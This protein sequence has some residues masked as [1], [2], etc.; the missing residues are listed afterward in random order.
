VGTGADVGPGATQPVETHQHFR[1]L[2]RWRGRVTEV[3]EQTFRAMLKEMDR[4]LPEREVA[5]YVSEVSPADRPLL[6]EGAIFY[7]SIGYVDTLGGQRT[8]QSAIRFQRRPGWTA[9]DQRAA[10]QWAARMARLV[11]R[12]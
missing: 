9:E 7:W 10:E 12:V 1:T 4:P 3:G 11:R 5:I 6:L 2:A 8:R